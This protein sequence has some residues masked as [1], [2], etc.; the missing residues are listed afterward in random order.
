MPAL[1]AGSSSLLVVDL[2]ERL[3]PAIS[4]ATGVLRNAGRLV[5][6]A[7][8][9]GVDVTTTEQD[10][11]KLGPT[12][13]EIAELLPAPAVTKSTF[14]AELTFDARVVVCGCEAHVCVLQT[15]LALRA[16]G[17]DVAVVA[18]AVGSRSEHDRDAAIARMRD[19]GVEVVTTEMVVF[20]WLGA[21]TNP[22]FREVQG[23]IK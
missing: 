22:A 11:A 18:D 1:T 2:Q 14:A 23:L 5:R 15:V 10:P 4:G 8:R 17:H 6:A 20:E 21:S 16:G 19:H 7:T 3:M 13:G 9:L 12:V